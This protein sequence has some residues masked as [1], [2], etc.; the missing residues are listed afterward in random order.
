MQKTIKS[1]DQEL[2]ALRVQLKEKQEKEVALLEH[3]VELEET[4]RGLQEQISQ[5]EQEIMDLEN[6]FGDLE[7][8]MKRAIEEKQDSIE[9]LERKIKRLNTSL[10]STVT[11][12]SHSSA[13]ID[14][15]CPAEKRAS[16]QNGRVG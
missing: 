9:S 13:A 16:G 3:N 6:R 1:S 4:C 10:D 15:A 12:C 5:K 7:D 2:K 8:Q 14:F 11:L